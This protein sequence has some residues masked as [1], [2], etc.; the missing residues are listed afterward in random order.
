MPAS[1]IRGVVGDT[2]FWIEAFDPAREHHARAAGLLEDLRHHVILMPWP[3]T[4]EILRTRTVKNRIRVSAFQRVL[5]RKILKIDDSL[6]RTGCLEAGSR[7]PQPG[8]A[9]AMDE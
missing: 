8:R 2:S 4:Y 5:R 9:F 7:S 6:Y 1:S 3:I